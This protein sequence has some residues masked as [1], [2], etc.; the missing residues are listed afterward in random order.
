MDTENKTL[1]CIKRAQ[2]K[3]KENHREKMTAISM[4]YHNKNKNSPD[5]KE[6]RKEY[7]R[8]YLEKKK[9]KENLL[10]ME[11]LGNSIN[12]IDFNLQV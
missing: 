1:A 4:K 8:K 11:S 5:Y 12:K 9:E 3:Y 6:K 2:K 7:Q 10:K